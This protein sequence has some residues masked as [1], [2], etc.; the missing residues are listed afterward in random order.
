MDP[1][2][3]QAAALVKQALALVNEVGSVPEVLPFIDENIQGRAYQI[4]SF[5]INA[6]SR[7]EMPL[8]DVQ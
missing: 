1:R 5:L 6:L 8:K 2:F 7:L 4:Q 3:V